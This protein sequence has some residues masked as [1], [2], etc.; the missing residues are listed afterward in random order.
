[1]KTLAPPKAAMPGF[2]L[3]MRTS[4]LDE[5]KCDGVLVV[6]A[7]LH[8]REGDDRED[9]AQSPRGKNE[10]D[11]NEDERENVADNFCKKHGDLKVERL[12]AQ[13]VRLGA[14]VLE[15]YPD[16]ERRQDAEDAQNL[17]EA[18]IGFVFGWCEFW[19]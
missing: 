4:L 16:N 9:E 10:N 5:A 2:E 19:C 15:D 13:L 1:M 11:T 17:S 6:L 3:L 14:T 8:L 18:G 12:F 7:G